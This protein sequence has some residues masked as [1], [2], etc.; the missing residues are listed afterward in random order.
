MYLVDGETIAV[1]IGS[2]RLHRFHHYDVGLAD[3]RS[4]S[5]NKQW[6]LLESLCENFGVIQW[7][8]HA[9]KFGA[10]KQQ[11]SE[12]RRAL[13]AI[14]GIHADPFKRCKQSDGLVA[15]FQAHPEPPNSSQY[16]ESLTLAG[17]S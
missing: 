7:R 5:P 4:G 14:F 16:D 6:R 12:L 8:C 9:G 3:R 1:R 13:Q 2:G 10:F 11:V 17:G 15:A